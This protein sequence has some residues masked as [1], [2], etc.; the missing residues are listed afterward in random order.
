MHL[1]RSA[2]IMAFHLIPEHG[3]TLASFLSHSGMWKHFLFHFNIIQEFESIFYFISISL[4]NVGAH[5]NSFTFHSGMWKRFIF[6]SDS[7]WNVEGHCISFTSYSRTWKHIIF[8]FRLIPE[9]GS[10]LYFI[11]VIFRNV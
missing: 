2:R 9:C 11:Y 7:F 3:N 6:I 4:R 5:Y 8:H 1:L 10:T